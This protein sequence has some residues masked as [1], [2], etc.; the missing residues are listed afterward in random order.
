M[1]PVAL[2]LFGTQPRVV[3]R[4]VVEGL[5]APRVDITCPAALRAEVQRELTWR[6]EAMGAQGRRDAALGA[7]GTL[8]A[9]PGSYG[10]WDCR[11]CGERGTTGD[12][13]LCNAAR[14][15]A[16]RDLGR[17]P[18]PEPR[19]PRPWSPEPQ[20]SPRA[21]LTRRPRAELPTWTCRVCGKVQV[22]CYRDRDDECGPCELERVTT[23]L[24]LSGR[25]RSRGAA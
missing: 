12:C 3:I 25:S 21:P 8:L 15:L 20:D 17:L 16:L 6:R 4:L 9:R 2:D 24:D 14:V 11:S 13:Q 10:R 19:Q 7:H 23:T 1:E 5:T 18:A 22:N